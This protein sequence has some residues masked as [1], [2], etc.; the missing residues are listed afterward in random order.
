MK[1][2]RPTQRRSARRT[3]LCNN[4]ALKQGQNRT[5]KKP[6]NIPGVKRELWPEKIRSEGENNACRIS[7]CTSQ[8]LS[9]SFFLEIAAT[10]EKCR[11]FKLHTGVRAC[12][13][14]CTFTIKHNFYA[15]KLYLV[16]RAVRRNK[17]LLRSV[18]YLEHLRKIRMADFPDEGS[19]P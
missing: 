11:F 14:M 9:I 5:K 8:C 4:S 18:R 3:S 16:R 10:Y 1:E 12:R 17:V 13:C 15:L 19:F 6:A 7:H 2:V